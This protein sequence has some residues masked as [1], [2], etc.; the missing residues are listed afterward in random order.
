MNDVI[1]PMSIKEKIGSFSKAMQ[2]KDLA[3][4]FGVTKDLI[5]EQAR[6]GT[7]PSFRIGTAVR[8]DPKRVSEWYDKQ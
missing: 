5:Y 8:F 4:I 7:I 6:L 2:A 3:G 1:V